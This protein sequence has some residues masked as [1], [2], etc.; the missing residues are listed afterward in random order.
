[1]T[2]A[3]L[4]RA[5][6]L[7]GALAVFAPTAF[8]A[9]PPAER[10]LALRY[11]PVVRVV[12][13]SYGCEDGEPYLPID[14]ETLFGNDEVVLR[15]PWSGANIVKIAPEVADVAPGRVGYHLDF[16]GDALNPG[17]SYLEWS[18]RLNA[19]APPTVYAHVVTQDG[20]LA[21]Q[22][23]LFYV[24]ND[25]N[26]LHEGDWEMVQLVFDAATPQQAL[27]GPPTEIG[28]SQ[29]EGAERARWGDSKLALV[30]GTH[31]V[32]YPAAGSHA[33]FFSQGLFLGRSA[34][35]GVGCDD[36]QGTYRSLRPR[37]AVVPSVRADYL[38]A[39]P[40][41]G[42]EGRWGERQPV[43][44]NGP[45]G[46]NLKPQ[47]TEPISWS[48]SWRN[49]AFSVFDGVSLGPSATEF[50]C[51]AV[52]AGSGLLTKL[53]RNPWA[54]LAVIGLVVALVGL[55]ASRTKWRRTPPFALARRRA[56]GEIV[57]VARTVYRGRFRLFA[58]IGL[59]FIPVGVVIALLQYLLFRVVAFA[60]LVH[61]AGES[62]VTVA[63]LAFSMGLL[64]TVLALSFVQAAT[65]FA[66]TA[67][68]REDD[69]RAIRAYRAALGRLSALVWAVVRAAV[70]I[71]LLDL[72]V[73]GIPVS[74]WLVVRWSLVAQVVQLE[75][76]PRKRTLR[77]SAAL[78]RGHWLR[79]AVFTLLVTGLGLLSGVVAGG[80]LLLATNASFNIVNIVA[81]LVY[82]VA[83][84]YVAIATTYLYYDL[85]TR[86]V[87]RE[88]MP[89]PQALPAEV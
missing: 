51:G 22:Y 57:V 13:T 6:L 40:W 60:P 81:A 63:G 56:F 39:F 75:D 69:V 29:H 72:T 78:V 85:H 25:F 50:F 73:I 83:M 86:S 55:L 48:E 27:A 9:A 33:N 32:V 54:A 38:R 26:N 3:T 87:L 1:M 23:W 53:V 59:L 2:A 34:A 8:A 58:G 77:R 17:C 10:E 52:G 70:I 31:P 61:T 89:V 76:E 5:L 21:L 88:R 46:P 14:V 66:L 30:D 84:P 65:A 12:T 82:A 16:P 18:K 36:T 37:V 11:S 47:W 68:E 7:L 62:N 42:F 15:G 35:Q 28:Y 45:T 20:R 44:F 43:F 19:L 74:I 71:A 80:L 24:Y 79:V 41:L 49:D 4:R 64:F 67:A